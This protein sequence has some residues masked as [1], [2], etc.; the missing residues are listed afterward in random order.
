MSSLPNAENSVFAIDQTLS[1]VTIDTN[2][3]CFSFQ[4]LCGSS[5]LRSLQSE[6]VNNDDFVCITYCPKNPDFYPI[7]S[8]PPVLEVLQDLVEQ[9]LVSLKRKFCSVNSKRNISI[10]EH[11]A[12]KACK[13]NC[14]LVVRKADKGGGGG[15]LLLFLM[16]VYTKNST[17][18]F[19][20][21]YPYY[22]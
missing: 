17:W 8:W 22:V 4:D 9:D 12:I 15:V 5:P 13:T 20:V 7:P 21:V 18:I 19:C 16:V 2:L 6:S 10:H 3:P 1:N 11:Q 14:D